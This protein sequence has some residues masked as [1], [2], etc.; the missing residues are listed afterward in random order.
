MHAQLY[1]DPKIRD[2]VFLPLC[3]LMVAVQVMRIYGM[4][5]MNEPKNK[6]LDPANL[7]FKTLHG[8]IFEADADLSRDM[9]T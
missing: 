3:L 4:R 7:A 2:Y 8:T 5:F 9:P 1:I 6:L